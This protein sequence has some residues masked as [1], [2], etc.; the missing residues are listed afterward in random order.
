MLDELFAADSYREVRKPLLEA[1]TLA[2]HCYTSG[3]FFQRE[4][5]R[6]FRRQWQFVG[7][8]EQLDSPGS[9]FCHDGPGFSAIILREAG[10]EIRAF[11][12]S[13]RH[14]GARLLEGSGNCKRIVC[15]YHSWTYQTDG[16][17]TG[18]PGMQEAQ[19]FD[20]SDYS[21]LE[22]RVS[23]WQ[24]F[25]FVHPNPDPP[26]LADHLGNMPEIFNGH[27]CAQ[28]QLVGELE[29]DID[30]NW[31]LLVENALEAYHTGSVHRDSLGQ[32]Q[33]RPIDSLDDCTGLLVEEER[34]VATLP[35]ADKPFAHIEGLGTD[36]RSGAFFTM[37]YPST[38]L[39]FAQDCMW[40]LAFSPIA[41]DRT[42]LHIG[43]CFPRSTVESSGF[44]ERVKPYFDRW[45][46]ATAEDNTI[47]E[48]Q[49]R[50][51]R[52]TRSPGRYAG[53]EFA[54]HA[55]DNWVLD[56]LLEEGD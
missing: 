6:I 54:L 10:G 26:S 56:Q 22:L 25:V 23:S 48:Q 1:S 50:G 34:S 35:G 36:A 31:K 53:S 43:A 47:C 41:V 39:V 9:Y 27:N 19:A 13:C 42:H 24:G 51:Q 30:C 21:L 17:L 40:W 12:N 14:R 15:P 7:R 55:F 37:L 4:M 45:R 16:R 44:D 33:S 28:M 2:P 52:V 46:Q 5:A 32:H 49:Q 18:T 20:P 38:Q 8:E 29:F 3:V 11:F